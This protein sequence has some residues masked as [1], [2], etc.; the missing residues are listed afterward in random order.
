MKMLP[1]KDFNLQ[2]F[3]DCITELARSDEIERALW[4]CDNLPAYYRDN[5][6]QEIIDLK[7]HIESR[8]AT[9]VTYS[10]DPNHLREV[11]TPGFFLTG[12]MTLRGALIKKDVKSFNEQSLIPHVVDLGPGNFWVPEMLKQRGLQYTYEP[13]GV[14]LGCLSVAKEKIGFDMEKKPISPVIFLAC[15][16]IEHLWNESEI[17]HNMLRHCGWAD[18]I[19][20]STPKYTFGF[21]L[22]KDWNNKRDEIEHLRAY[23]PGEFTK[24]IG[25]MFAPKYAN[26]MYDSVV[27]HIRLL[28]KDS[29]YSLEAMPDIESDLQEINKFNEL[30]SMEKI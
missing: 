3:I 13:L 4:L 24:L 9:A 22:G 5:K 7:N 16:V 2:C 12:E 26:Y 25:D 28:K 6:P 11:N 19:H 1:I 30:I 21:N 27:M 15:E 10:K 20:V 18:I 8:L 23:T 17:K 14:H 29:P